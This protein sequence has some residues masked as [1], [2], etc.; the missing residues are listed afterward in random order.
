MSLRQLT[1]WPHMSNDRNKIQ[2]RLLLLAILV[3][4]LRRRMQTRMRRTKN[5]T[6]KTSWMG[7]ANCETNKVIFPMNPHVRTPHPTKA[8]DESG[9]DYESGNDAHK[10]LENRNKRETPSKKRMQEETACSVWFTKMRK[11]AKANETEHEQARHLRLK[12]KQKTM[13]K[14]MPTRVRTSSPATAVKRQSGENSH[15]TV[16][17]TSEPNRS[18]RKM[19]SGQMMKPR[20]K[21]TYRSKDDTFEWKDGAAGST[22]RVTS[23]EAEDRPGKGEEHFRVAQRS[24]KAASIL[25]SSS[26]N[27]TRHRLRS[28]STGVTTNG[29]E[30]TTRAEAE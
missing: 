3:Y 11:S 24:S 26:G 19:W 18:R 12:Q 27:S 14:T 15:A 4:M 25:V 9:N 1:H 17:M 23:D 30:K 16:Q 28:G 10:T 21:T 5:R 13:I 2:R 29:T 22:G 6:W 20:N 7:K 8:N